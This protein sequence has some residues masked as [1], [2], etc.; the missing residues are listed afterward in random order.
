ME[1]SEAQ[2]R[3]LLHRSCE[4]TIARVWDSTDERGPAS[5]ARL[6]PIP[7]VDRLNNLL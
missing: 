7:P 4:I 5:I 1:L 6:G 3:A 2:A